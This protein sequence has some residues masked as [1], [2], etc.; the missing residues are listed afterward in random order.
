M[1]SIVARSVLP[2]APFQALILIFCVP[3]QTMEI[4]LMG[5]ASEHTKGTWGTSTVTVAVAVAEH[6]WLPKRYPVAVA[7]FV[8]VPVSSATTS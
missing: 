8:T 6:F 7:I 4:E 2:T 5:L 1:L 3:F